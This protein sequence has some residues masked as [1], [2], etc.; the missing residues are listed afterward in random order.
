[1]DIESKEGRFFFKWH[2]LGFQH[3]HDDLFL[4]KKD[5]DMKYSHKATAREVN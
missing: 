2:L 4:R 3:E 1:M 5:S